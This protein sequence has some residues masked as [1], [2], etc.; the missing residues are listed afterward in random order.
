MTTPECID[1]AFVASANYKWRFQGGGFANVLNSLPQ[2]TS[3]DLRGKSPD[4]S[5]SGMWGSQHE[6]G[7]SKSTENL[8]RRQFAAR[9]ARGVD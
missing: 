9:D 6:W 1:V 3:R 7:K 4:F 8:E 5:V 2:T